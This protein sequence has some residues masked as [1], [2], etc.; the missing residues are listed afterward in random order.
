VP[1]YHWYA[2]PAVVGLVIIASVGLEAAL[3]LVIRMVSPRVRTPVSVL[4]MTAAVIWCL[5]INFNTLRGLPTTSAQHPMLQIYEQAG[6]WLD[7]HAPPAATVGYFEIGYLGYYAHRPIVDPLG[8][9][10][11]AIPPHIAKADFLWAYREHPPDY[12]LEQSGNSFGGIRG[13]AWFTRGYQPVQTFTH[14]KWGVSLT[15][16]QRVAERPAVALH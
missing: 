11:P 7:A 1:F 14:P 9:L 3:T 13:E 16:F 5:V 15:V 10:D 8:L 2:A 6:R 12:I 4:A